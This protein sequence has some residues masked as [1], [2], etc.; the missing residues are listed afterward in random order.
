MAVRL[1]ALRHLPQRRPPGTIFTTT[2]A[3]AR[4]LKAMGYAEDAPMDA[5][6]PTTPTVPTPPPEPPPVVPHGDPPAEDDDETRDDPKG[7][8]ATPKGRTYKR[9]DL[10]AES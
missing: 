10:E 9:R 4:A 7:K 6:H 3:V 8:A 1:R 2:Q 5:Q